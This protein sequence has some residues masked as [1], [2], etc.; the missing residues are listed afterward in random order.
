MIVMRRGSRGAAVL[1]QRVAHHPSVRPLARRG[2]R[3][4]GRGRHV[5]PR[6]AAAQ[7]IEAAVRL[8]GIL[9]S[10]SALIAITQPFLPGYTAARCCSSRS[11][12]S[13]SCSGAPRRACR[14]RAGCRAGGDRGARRADRRQARRG[15]TARATRSSRPARCSPGSA[16]RCA[17]RSSPIAR[18]WAIRSRT[19]SCAA[20][21]ARPSSRSSAASEGF[22]V[23]DPTRSAA[24]R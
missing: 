20:R 24:R 3:A 6:P 8:V 5:G 4:A 9:I 2:R 21:P 11:S 19:S 22:A 18:R 1:R 15:R 14:P 10:G 23:P 16:R 13:P 12:C 17:T 7:D